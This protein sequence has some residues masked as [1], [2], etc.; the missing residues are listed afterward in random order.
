MAI[1]QVRN[2]VSLYHSR[3][4]WS[5]EKWLASRYILKFADGLDVGSESERKI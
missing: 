4:N 2:I 1:I 3:S 5:D